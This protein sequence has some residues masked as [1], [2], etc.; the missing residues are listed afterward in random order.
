LLK[1][2]TKRLTLCRI[3]HKYKVSR[4][5]V[6]WD[7][8]ACWLSG[9]KF[10]HTTHTWSAC[11]VDALPGELC[12]QNLWAT[13]NIQSNSQVSL[14]IFLAQ[15]QFDGKDIHLLLFLGTV[16]YSYCRVKVTLFIHFYI[17]FAIKKERARNSC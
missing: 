13:C 5:S 10:C 8:A 17:I 12:D 4:R 1:E 2:R 6:L 3:C 16:R 14:Q 9:W 11:L 15:K 7:V